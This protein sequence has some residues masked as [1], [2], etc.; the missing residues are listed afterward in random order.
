[1]SAL[2]HDNTDIIITA[3]SDGSGG[4]TA[5]LQRTVTADTD[6]KCKATSTAQAGSPAGEATVSASVY[7]K[8]Y[9]S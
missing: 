6:F 2:V 9:V 5:T 4:I 8:L 3:V 1:V 7:S